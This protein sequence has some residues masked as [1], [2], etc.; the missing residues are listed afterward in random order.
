[1]Q[2]SFG[3]GCFPW[4]GIGKVVASPGKQ[5]IA[6]FLKNAKGK[7]KKPGKSGSMAKCVLDTQPTFSLEATI[8]QK[9]KI[10]HSTNGR[11]FPIFVKD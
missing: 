10:I 7:P 11:P 6:L 4:Y 8:P 9:G 5:L 3:L 2:A 1:M